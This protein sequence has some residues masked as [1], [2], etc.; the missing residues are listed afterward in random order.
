MEGQ[1]EKDR[2]T[3]RH[4]EARDRWRDETNGEADR[5]N[6]MAVYLTFIS[7][8]DSSFC[9]PFGLFF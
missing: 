3:D 8:M 7:E 5:S 6:H 4:M 2:G 1:R 9:C